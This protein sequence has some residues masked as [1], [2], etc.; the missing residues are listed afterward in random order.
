MLV[1]TG[2]SLMPDGLE[3]ALTEQAMTDLVAY[4]AGE[5]G[6]ASGPRDARR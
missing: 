3:A 4:L 2:R 5:V 6:K 1:S